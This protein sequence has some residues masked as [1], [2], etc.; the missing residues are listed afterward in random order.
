MSKSGIVVSGR[1]F[2][3][4]VE[5]VEAAPRQP[6]V[7][8]KRSDVALFVGKK[9]V[10]AALGEKPGKRRSTAPEM[11][12]VEKA[13]A[14]IRFNAAKQLLEDADIS[15][16]VFS[17]VED[18][19]AALIQSALAAKAS[20]DETKLKRAVKGREAK[21]DERDVR[22]VLSLITW[23]G[24]LNP[25]QW[26]KLPSQIETFQNDL[27]FALMGDWGTG[28]YG[29]PNC[30]KSINLAG[31]FDYV[32][33]LGDIY[34]SGTMS[35][36]KSN[37]LEK[38]VQ[39]PGARYRACNGNHEMYSGGY[40]Y[41]DSVLPSF[42][43][44]SSCFAIT[45]KDWLIVGLD[46]AYTEHDLGYSQGKW[47]KK[48]ADAA[49]GK[50][51]VLFTHH[52][53][54]SH[55]DSGG[56][57]LINKLTDL[58]SSQRITAWYWGHEHRC[59]VYDRHPTWNFY[60]RCIGHGGYPYFREPSLVYSLAAKPKTVSYG[61]WRELPANTDRGAP[62]AILL[63]GPNPDLGRYKDKYGPN[64]YVTLEFTGKTLT[65]RYFLPTGQELTSNVIN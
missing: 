23:V 6:A 46:S 17:T 54:F 61:F 53:P 48:L 56:E 8:A 21:F 39:V 27:K 12:D 32:V 35:E 50:K 38:W 41:F 4:T 31:G 36:A 14:L 57:K 2:A 3:R 28:L 22:W 64:G 18:Q 43:Q 7:R 10:E 33:H 13:S 51:L 44:P 60:G 47:V 20:Q 26:K 25:H 49:P 19:M 45:N 37:F 63:D 24:K 40:G 30:A 52:Q 11:S 34:Y 16:G 9:H 1:R 65:E 15:P 55:F 58:L 42:D 62:R 5:A 29:A 59:V